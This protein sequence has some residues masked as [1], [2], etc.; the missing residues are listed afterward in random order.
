MKPG[1]CLV[2]G[3]AGFVG[4][5]ISAGL[6]QRFE[7]VVAFDNLHPQVHPRR[8]RPT[9]LHPNVEFVLGDVS[10][11]KAWELLLPDLRPST[12]IHL[13]AE[14]GTGQSLTEATRHSQVNVVGTAVMM[15]ALASLDVLPARMILTSS[16][17]VYGEGAWRSRRDGTI[18]YP[19]QRTREQLARAEWDFP[20]LEPEPASA[21]TTRPSPAS[22]Y[23]AT[24]LA[25]EHLM[26]A[27]ATAF[28]SELVVLR[29]QNV[30]GPGQSLANPY[31]G[32]VPAFCR[33][34]RNGESI[35]LYEDGRM[36]RDFVFID[37]VADAILRAVDIVNVPR[38]ALDIG[39]A[40]GTSI[41]GL[42]DRVTAIY[43]A[44]APHV[45]GAYRFGDVRHANCSI[46]YAQSQLGWTPRQGLDTGLAHL[47]DWIDHELERS[48]R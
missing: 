27:W 6:A 16:R 7:R 28:G 20:G 33:F 22:I 38:Y 46:D 11:V 9:A 24:K 4:C 17:A 31:T 39:T 34:A 37:D 47:T 12:V 29:L 2:T 5:A 36:M 35:P 45:C 8:V 48:P 40:G 42:A 23:G 44:P 18:Y 21:A 43:D 32:I 19:G 14:T 30:Y 3:G 26:S 13:A 15:D 41:A 25:Q 1:S 10:D